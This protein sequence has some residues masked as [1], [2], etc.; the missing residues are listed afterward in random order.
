MLKTPMKAHA[1]LIWYPDPDEHYLLVQR[2]A[3]QKREKTETFVVGM[4]RDIE[5]ENFRTQQEVLQAR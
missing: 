2:R 4:R 1:L 5:P 3:T